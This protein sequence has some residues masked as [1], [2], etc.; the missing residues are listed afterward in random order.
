MTR[1]V[2]GRGLMLAVVLAVSTFAA[3]VPASADPQAESCT[4]HAVVVVEPGPGPVAICFDGTIT[5]LD[6]LQLAGADPVTYGFAGQG[7]AVCKLYGV[8]NPPD[9][10]LIGPGGQYWAYYRAAPGASGWT[11]SRGG[12]GATTVTDGSMEGWRYGTGAA[13]SFPSYCSVVG[14][15]PPPT[16]APLAT[17]A[18][19]ATEAQPTTSGGA[20]SGQDSST[21][22]VSPQHGTGGGQDG[23]A[24]KGTDENGSSGA[25]ADGAGAPTSESGGRRV[26]SGN[27]RSGG[28]VALAAGGGNGGAG[29]PMGL[30]VAIVVVAAGVGA[31]LWVRVRRRRA[32]GAAGQ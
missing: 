24:T 20:T 19:P 21:A 25:A 8:G 23:K 2:R 16:Q 32:G 28:M 14:C 10:C 4:A 27:R 6:A 12:A 3:T 18:P 29:S 31:G 13:P 5:G 26:S 1:G 11:Y 17:G 30:V 9:S 22:G 15:A 7:A